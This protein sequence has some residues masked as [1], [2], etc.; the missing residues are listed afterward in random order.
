[1]SKR[2]APAPSETRR[3]RP[4]KRR[5]GPGEVPAYAQAAPHR[6][7]QRIARLAVPR[8]FCRVCGQAVAQG[9]NGR[10]RS[11]HDGRATAAGEREPN[12]LHTYKIATRPSYGKTFVA[13]RDG[14]KCAKCGADR[15]RSYAWLHLDHI[16]PLADG[17]EAIESNLQLLCPDCHTAKT[18]DE[19][20]ERA[21][22][23]REAKAA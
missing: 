7:G 2:Q 21:K 10:V 5:Y 3:K 6:H 9:R 1:M 11:W 22:R 13:K 8:G 19:N 16:V 15:G 12:C 14:R 17:G 18:A 4:R 23:R 20:S